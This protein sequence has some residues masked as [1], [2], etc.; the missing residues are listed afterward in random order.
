MKAFKDTPGTTVQYQ[1]INYSN[2][3][4]EV[5][6]VKYPTQAGAHFQWALPIANVAMDSEDIILRM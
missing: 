6:F 5:D 4:G 3:A 1:A 2:L